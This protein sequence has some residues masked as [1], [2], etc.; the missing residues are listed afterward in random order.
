MQKKVIL[1][2]GTFDPIHTG[3]LEVAQAARA[4]L[5]AAEVIFIPA[6]R[7]PHKHTAP[8][9]SEQDRLHMLRLAVQGRK[10]LEVSDCEY[11]RPAPSFTVDTVRA[12]RDRMPLACLIW[13]VGADAV[14]DLPRWHQIDR[15]MTLCTLAV[16]VRAGYPKPDFALCQPYFSPEQIRQLEANIVPVPLLDIS[17]TEI[18]RRLAEGEDVSG[19][20]PPPV[21]EYIRS[22]GLYGCRR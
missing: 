6:R 9:A 22:E 2:G 20:L 3:H 7:S 11:H 13:L 16:M 10:G 21:L 5:N 8:V 12:F 4:Y 18:R 15:L 1:F 19:L 14:K 17:A